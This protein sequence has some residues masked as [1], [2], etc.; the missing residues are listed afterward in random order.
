MRRLTSLFMTSSM[1]LLMLLGC[2]AI[3]PELKIDEDASSDSGEADDT[4]TSTATAVVTDSNEDSVGSDGTGD[5]QMDGTGTGTDVDTTLSDTTSLDTGS[6]VDSS[7]ST[8]ENTDDD[9]GTADGT[10]TSL[11]TGTGAEVDTGLDSATAA[12]TDDDSETQTQPLS[13]TDSDTVTDTGMGTDSTTIPDSESVV[14]TSTMAIDT[15]TIPETDTETEPSTDCAGRADFSPCIVVTSPEDR[16]YDICIDEVCESPGCGDGTC[17]APGPHFPLADSGVTSCYTGSAEQVCA[18]LDALY[19]GQDAQFGWDA[20]TQSTPRF[21]KITDTVNYP[22]VQ[23]NV[24]G[25]MWQGCTVGLTGNSCNSSSSG[26]QL[27][28]VQAVARCDDLE[29]A[30]YD[31]WHLPD[32]YELVSI[33][34]LSETQPAVADMFPATSATGTYW[35]ATSHGITPDVRWETSFSYGTVY[36][37]SNN[38]TS[39]R[40]FARCVRG[41]PSAR[42][43]T[44]YRLSAVEGESLVNDDVTGLMWPGCQVVASTPGIPECAGGSTSTGI[45]WQTALAFC[46]S[47]EWGGETDWRLPNMKELHSI[48]DYREYNP[49]VNSDVFA[50]ISSTRFWTSTTRSGVAT[51]AWYV[52]ML[53]GWVGTLQ[54]TETSSTEGSS[55]T[56]QHAAFCVRAGNWD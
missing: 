3:Y 56:Y 42:P 10:G 37:P 21:T 36:T 24:T 11:D 6:N 40:T 2:Q 12:E 9:S 4:E 38:D 30:G 53:T 52:N 27:T 33:L 13:D 55:T 49:T 46:Q 45:D 29:W 22:V 20:A 41:G 1:L 17:N 44:R 25:L 31:D 26:E 51:H 28:W 5:T 19:D 39:A 32:V 48:V 35:T 23:D 15:S 16:A 18:E 47:L 43:S 8:A 54:K 50:N 7:T 34:D 14:D